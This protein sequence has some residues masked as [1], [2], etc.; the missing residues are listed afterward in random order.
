MQKSD[1]KAFVVA[2]MHMLNI[3]LV[4]ESDPSAAF[5][6]DKIKQLLFS[7][8]GFPESLNKI[9]DP[10]LKFSRYTFHLTATADVSEAMNE[11]FNVPAFAATSVFPEM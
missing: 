8:I 10:V 7:I 3:H 4:A 1:P 11:L 5:T 6:V 2:E 9:A